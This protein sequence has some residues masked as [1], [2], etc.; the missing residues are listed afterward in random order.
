ML[1]DVILAACQCVSFKYGQLKQ[2]LVGLIEMIDWQYVVVNEEEKK[3]L[4][5]YMEQ[6]RSRIAGYEQFV[7]MTGIPIPPAINEKLTQIV[8]SMA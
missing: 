8:I 4:Q 7:G 1:V 2:K 6:S 3:S 5:Q